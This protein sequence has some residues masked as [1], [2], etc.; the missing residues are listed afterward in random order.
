[1]LIADDDAIVRDV[2]G[3]ATIAAAMHLD[4]RITAVRREIHELREQLY[5]VAEAFTQRLSERA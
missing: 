1:V 4:R 5:D 2:E 3:D